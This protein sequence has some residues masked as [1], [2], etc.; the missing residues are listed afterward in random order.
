[1]QLARF[2]SMRKSATHWCSAIDLSA[3]RL[4]AGAL[5]LFAALSLM[6]RFPLAAATQGPETVAFLGVHFQNDNAGLEPTTDA[7]RKRLSE[8]EDSFKQQLTASGRFKFIALSAS[9]KETIKA[10]QMV[11]ACGGC[12]FDYGRQAGADLV[13]WMRVQKVSNL[14]LNLN[15]YIGRVTD[16]KLVFVHSVDMRGNTDESWMRSLTY[17]VQN[18]LLRPSSEG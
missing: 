14:I 13:A 12:E 1:M 16:R 4:L 18:Y 9:E 10:G 7:E 6:A 15:V 17:L 11:G 5:C 3:R 2:P 8:I